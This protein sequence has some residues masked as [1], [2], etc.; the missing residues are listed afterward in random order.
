MKSYKLQS[1]VI[2]ER[3]DKR[4]IKT[5]SYRAVIISED[6]EMWVTHGM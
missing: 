6:N 3:G 1:V 5:A 2:L 4:D